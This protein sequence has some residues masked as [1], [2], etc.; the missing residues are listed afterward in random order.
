MNVKSA[1]LLF[2]ALLPCSS[3]AESVLVAV[4]SNFSQPMTDIAA[5]F[6]H[7]TGHQAKLAFASSGKLSA[8]IMHGA[9]FDIFLSADSDKPTQLIQ[10]GFAVAGTQWTYALG[11][12]ALWSSDHDLISGDA[13]VLLQQKAF[14]RLAI[15]EPQLAPYGQAAMAVLEKLG[16]QKSLQKTLVYGEN[17]AQTYQFVATHNAELGFVARAQI[18]RH[19]KP[20]KGSS[21][22][23]P[24]TLHPP[25][26]QDAVLLNH[27]ENNEAAIAL[28]QYLKQAEIRNLI[29]EFGYDNAQ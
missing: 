12:L 1:I 9:P 29:K 2:C 6:H 21:W 24:S 5:R 26:K 28:M 27:G 7:E 10:R 23:V 16:L 4:A 11:R 13:Q 25:I 22:M 8:Q 19:D 3:Q 17:I 14:R 15:A 18:L 20:I